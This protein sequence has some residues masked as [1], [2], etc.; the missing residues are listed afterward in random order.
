MKNI[1][2]HFS[3]GS[4]VSNNTTNCWSDSIKK[5][6]IHNRFSLVRLGKIKKVEATDKG[7]P[8]IPRK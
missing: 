1:T 2:I 6:P 4:K 8:G 3:N 5:G 7:K